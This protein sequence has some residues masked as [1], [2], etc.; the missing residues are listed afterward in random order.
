MDSTDDVVIFPEPPGAVCD[1]MFKK[2]RNLYEVALISTAGALF[3]VLLLRAAF[4]FG[5]G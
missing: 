5:F 3:L 4:A 2:P 1:V